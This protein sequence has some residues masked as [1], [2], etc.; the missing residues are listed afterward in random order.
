MFL[1]LGQVLAI[2]QGTRW[3]PSLPSQ[4]GLGNKAW[5]E[6]TGI[7]RRQQMK[8]IGMGRGQI[9]VGREEAS[10]DGLQRS[11]RWCSS[12]S[13]KGRAEPSRSLGGMQWWKL[14][15]KVINTSRAPAIPK[16]DPPLR[17]PS[18]PPAAQVLISPRV[19]FK[20]DGRARGSWAATQPGATLSPEHL[21]QR[22]GSP[23]LTFRQKC[24]KS[25]CM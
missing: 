23:S 14:W 6:S 10:V 16:Q 17:T 11:C 19:C 1:E 21:G 7:R 25:S 5:K 18:P 13:V 24:Q 22:E 12:E 15:K 2:Q 20:E 9:L 4:Q 8:G 3:N